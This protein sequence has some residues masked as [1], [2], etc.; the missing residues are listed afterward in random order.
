MPTAADAREP[1]EI[2]DGRRRALWIVAAT[3]VLFAVLPWGVGHVLRDGRSAPRVVP[4]SAARSPGEYVGSASCRVCHPGEWNAHQRSGHARTLR[5]VTQTG[6]AARLNGTTVADP[7]R[8]DVLWSYV[9]RGDALQIERREAGAVERYLADYAFGSGHHATTLATLTNRTPEHPVLLEHRLSVF[10]HKRLPDVTP[11]QGKGANDDGLGPAGRRHAPEQAVK[12]FECHATRTSD[13]GPTVL[14]EKTM[15]PTVDCERCHGPGGAHVAAA[16]R[17]QHGEALRMPFGAGRETAGQ[18][19]TMCGACHRLPEMGDP[20]LIRRDNPVLAR[21]QSVG[22]LQSACFRK[23]PGELSCTTC[24]DPHA[25]TSTDHAAY[26]AVCLSC[27]T[28]PSQRQ[29][30]VSPSTGCVGCH[31]PRRDV[32]RGMLITD[33]WIGVFNPPAD[34]RAAGSPSRGEKAP[35]ASVP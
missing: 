3:F 19:I 17:G 22:L 2:P 34:G 29:C 8:P 28:G 6:L 15:I 33:H 20:K 16:R 23:S 14:D 12:C 13:R 31:M 35:P 4:L 25:E 7:E 10:A 5:P 18:Q 11:G 32:S 9:A 1:V 27:H 24:H 26:E 21:F 30:R